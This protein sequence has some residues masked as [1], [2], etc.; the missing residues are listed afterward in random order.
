MLEKEKQQ[1]P[2]SLLYALVSLS[3]T[4]KTYFSFEFV[5]QTQKFGGFFNRKESIRTSYTSLVESLGNLANGKSELKGNNGAAATSSPEAKTTAS[6]SSTIA[7]VCSDLARFVSF[8]LDSIGIYSRL[9]KSHFPNS[10]ELK[11]RSSELEVLAKDIE[12]QASTKSLM[13][14]FLVSFSD[15][16]T[17]LLSL[18]HA[19]QHILLCDFADA[20]MYMQKAN[21][22]LQK[23]KPYFANKLGSTFRSGFFSFGERSSSSPS[24]MYTWYDK[25]FRMLN[26]K[27]FLYFYDTLSKELPTDEVRHAH[28]KLEFDYIGQ[29][30]TLLSKRKNDIRCISLLFI[31]NDATVVPK[32]IYNFPGHHNGKDNEDH[33]QV[34]RLFFLLLQQ[35]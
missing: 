30:K 33:T 23:W 31:S 19:N 29:T 1:L 21:D 2:T 8:R 28:G 10:S 13:K 18:L 12:N 32:Q 26:S 5:E 3:Y 34:C 6:N 27:F 14:E 24:A 20:V 9:S 7:N 4:E 15:E 25:F 22:V 35:I 17:L 16:L 11:A